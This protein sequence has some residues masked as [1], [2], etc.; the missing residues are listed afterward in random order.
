MEP[1]DNSLNNEKYFDEDYFPEDL[2]ELMEACKYN[3]VFIETLQIAFIDD[4]DKSEDD[5]DKAL[6][7]MDLAML[8]YDKLPYDLLLNLTF[9][10]LKTFPRVKL[11]MLY[12]VE[13]CAETFYNEDEIYELR[14][15]ERHIMMLKA[16]L[17]LS[18]CSIEKIE[19]VL[20]I[21]GDPSREEKQVIEDLT[22]VCVA[23]DKLFFTWNPARDKKALYEILCTRIEPRY[24]AVLTITLK[25]LIPPPV[26]RAFYYTNG[27][28]AVL[29]EMEKDEESDHI[30]KYYNLLAENERLKNEIEKIKKEKEETL[31]KQGKPPLR[32]FGLN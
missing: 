17:I 10:A 3:P 26:V 31:K 27:T 12:L 23:L 2:E 21:K 18:N 30:S 22:E 6:G 25:T 24:A 4:L 28:D 16:I 8:G 14:F 11:G 19:N 13:L 15:A 5:V 32:D 1:D 7:Y 20:T 29:D 9:K